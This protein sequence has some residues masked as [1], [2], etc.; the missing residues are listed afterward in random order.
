MAVYRLFLERFVVYSHDF[1]YQPPTMAVLRGNQINVGIDQVAMVVQQN[2]ATAEESAA[3]SEEMRGQSTMLQGLIAQFRI[4]GE[5]GG[6]RRALPGKAG[7][8]PITL[9]GETGLSV[10]ASHNGYGYN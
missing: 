8:K 2:S 9:S 3:A 6:N 1:E 4:K 5:D 10:T 7:R